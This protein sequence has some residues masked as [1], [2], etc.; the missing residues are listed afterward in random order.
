MFATGN[1]KMLNM[2][3]LDVLEQYS[4]EDHHL[5][6]QEIIRH[7]RAQYGMECDRR[8]VKNNIDALK[9]MGYD[10]VTN[11]KGAFL[12]GRKFDNAELRLLIDSVLFSK[13]ISQKRAKDLI[14]KLKE[15]GGLHFSAKVNHVCNLPELQHTDNKQT[16][17]ALDALN[18][19]IDK[20]KKVSFVYNSYGTDFQLHPRRKEPYIVNPYQIVANNGRYYLIANYDKYDN[21]AHFR[22]DR[23]TS[24][25][26][27]DE[28]RKPVS[29]VTDFKNG[30]SLPRHMAEHIYMF[31]GKSVS[32]RMVAKK[33]LMNELVDWFGK[34]FKIR[35]EFE[36]EMLVDVKCNAEA[37]RFW[38][39][40]YGPYVE[41]LEPAELREEIKK[42]VAEMYE[43][44][45]NSFDKDTGGNRK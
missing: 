3:I 23:M 7:L 40:Q 32:V 8:S 37:M 33:H 34:E 16:M 9:E 26:M 18:D 29:Q 22:I 38:A 36:D 13:G 20:K 28:K 44:Y 24:V 15:L 21:V 30:F 14:G 11:N 35:K 39:L 17:Y 31:S 6:Q 10:I 25:C 5:T 2:L 1:K 43:K 19:A 45:D 41:V 27:L 42:S 4:D 12:G